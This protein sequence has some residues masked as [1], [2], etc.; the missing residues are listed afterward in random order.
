MFPW[1]TYPLVMGNDVAGTIVEVGSSVSSDLKIGDRVI[2]NCLGMDK[3]VGK[4]GGN[5]V[6][7][8][9]GAFQKYVVL[10]A[11]M[12]TKIP[13]TVSYEAAAGIPLCASTAAAGL[14]QKD[15][16]ALDL[17]TNT[18]SKD[19]GKK[20]TVLIWGGSTSVGSNAIQ[21]AVASGYSVIVTC[22][23]ANNQY[24]KDL[25]AS[26][27]FNY[28]S[29]TV[30]ADI[31]KA[32]EGQIC[33]GA[34][35]LGS[36]GADGCIDVLAK[37]KCAPGKKFVAMATFPIPEPLSE[38]WPTLHL[39]TSVGYWMIKTIIR[40]RLNGV[41]WKFVLA[42]TVAGNE[43]GPA[44]FRDFLPKALQEG[45]YQAK[46]DPMVVGTGLEKVQEAMD[47]LKKGVSAKKVVVKLD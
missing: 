40:T 7:N 19:T 25:G 18:S 27:C 21:L 15:F 11:H 23:P 29:K 1:V 9:Q 46:P 26:K 42:T 39:M 33:A 2:G 10:Q 22:S 43:V 31:I 36:N 45:A 28:R 44:V 17:P 47:V 41:N 32:F 35:S 8:A 5:S 12:V 4:P 37:V 14:Y 16:L 6:Q 13:E 3:T 30:V 38:T 34:L 24:C 20:G